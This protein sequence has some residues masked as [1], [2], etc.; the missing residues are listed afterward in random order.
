MASTK[1]DIK[2]V[3]TSSAFENSINVYKEK[4]EIKKKKRKLIL[5]PIFPFFAFGSRILRYESNGY[6]FGGG[7]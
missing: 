1:M 6:G 4:N 3:A 2:S 5:N 7:F